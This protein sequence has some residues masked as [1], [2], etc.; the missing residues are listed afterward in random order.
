MGGATLAHARRSADPYFRDLYFVGRGLDIGAGGDPL[1]LPPDTYPRAEEVARWDYDTH[2]DAQY[3]TP[4]TAGGTYDYVHASHV[5]EH[6]HDP[7]IAVRA[8][9]G[10]VRPSG[11]LVILVPEYTLYER[12]IWPPHVNTDHKTT[13]VMGPDRGG[14]DEWWPA[15]LAEDCADIAILVRAQLLAYGWRG[16]LPDKQDQTVNPGVECAIEMVLR[17]RC[18]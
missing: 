9:L 11:H 5:L 13:W 4:E 8:W 2:G 14:A 3:L 6:V 16:D 10:V 18:G 12:R 15:R 17:K 7:G 1:T